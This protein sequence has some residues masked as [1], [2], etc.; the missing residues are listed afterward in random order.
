[1]GG[2]PEFLTGGHDGKVI[3]WTA[4]CTVAFTVDVKP[5]VSGNPGIRSLDYQNNQ[6]LVGTRGSEVIIVDQQSQ[7][8][9]MVV[10]GHSP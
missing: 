9:A 2:N 5:L 4:T 3:G 1:V 8:K 6:I 7:V 10:Q